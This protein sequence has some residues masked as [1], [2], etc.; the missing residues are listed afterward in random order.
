MH[1]IKTL[2]IL[3]FLSQVAI[4]APQRALFLDSLW[5]PSTWGFL[6]DPLIDLGTG[7]IQDFLM[8]SPSI[9]PSSSNSDN[10]AI[11][12]ELRSNKQF[13]ED[14]KES[15]QNLSSEIISYLQQADL[16]KTFE[17]IRALWNEM[18]S[19]LLTY[20]KEEFENEDDY[21]EI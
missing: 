13:L 11:L 7:S 6:V 21:R 2:L 5:S 17:E 1:L 8:P 15:I 19:L 14:I 20:N 4:P 3:A 18:T 10:I 9:P 12:N 16:N